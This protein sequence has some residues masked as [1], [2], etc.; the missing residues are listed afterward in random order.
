M[1]EKESM[2]FCGRCFRRVKK[3]RVALDQIARRPAEVLC[4]PCLMKERRVI[5]SATDRSNQ[6]AHVVRR[7]DAETGCARILEWSLSVV[8]VN[9]LLLPDADAEALRRRNVSSHQLF[10]RKEYVAVWRALEVEIVGVL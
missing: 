9:I 5:Q 7:I 2:A 8:N 10:C 1:A 6:Q 3:F 4:M